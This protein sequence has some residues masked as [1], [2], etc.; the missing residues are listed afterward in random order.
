MTCHLLSIKG[1]LHLILEALDQII[2]LQVGVYESSRLETFPSQSCPI[3]Q[4]I[5]ILVKI[6][7]CQALFN[8]K[9]KNRSTVSGETFSQKTA[10][11]TV[12]EVQCCTRYSF[13]FFKIVKIHVFTNSS[14][15]RES[16]SCEW[17][18]WA[19]NLNGV[20]TN[21]IYGKTRAT[22]ISSWISTSY[23][24]V[25]SISFIKKNNSPQTFLNT[26]TMQA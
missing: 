26:K 17:F 5:F 2:H 14:F 12:I 8:S 7:S 9:F 16:K 11:G 19:L 4:D 25:A 6:D 1:S 18:W 21:Q 3:Y 20:A 15:K 10:S 22:A 13:I 23:T 24:L